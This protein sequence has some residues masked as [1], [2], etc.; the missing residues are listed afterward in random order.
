MH[1]AQFKRNTILHC[2]IILE[3]LYSADS[4]IVNH[5]K[6]AQAERFARALLQMELDTMSDCWLYEL[7]VLVKALRDDLPNCSICDYSYKL[8]HL[9]DRLNRA[10]DETL[11]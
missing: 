8:N 11:Q 2:L 7:V 4:V 1:S 10:I 6:V 9:A 3:G 5:G